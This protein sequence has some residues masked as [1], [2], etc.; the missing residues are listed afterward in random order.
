VCNIV[1]SFPGICIEKQV[2]RMDTPGSSVVKSEEE[3]SAAS[4]ILSLTQKDTEADPGC[5][6]PGASLDGFLRMPGEGA[7]R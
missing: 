1:L 2:T 6:V 4:R 3:D 7:G 5:D